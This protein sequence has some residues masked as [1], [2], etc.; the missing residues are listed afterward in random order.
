MFNKIHLLSN[1]PK[2]EY[3][4]KSELEYGPTINVFRG[5]VCLSYVKKLAHDDWGSALSGLNLLHPIVIS[6]KYNLEKKYLF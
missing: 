3:R 4:K 1:E 6:I 2:I 5:K